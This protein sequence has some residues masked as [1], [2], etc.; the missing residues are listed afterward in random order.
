MLLLLAKT[1]YSNSSI[2]FERKLLKKG[3][4]HA[5]TFQ[6]YLQTSSKLAKLQSYKIFRTYKTCKRGTPSNNPL[7]AL[8][9]RFVPKSLEE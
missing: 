9:R 5:Q 3:K 2:W 7:R 8:R 6:L 1:P 4:I